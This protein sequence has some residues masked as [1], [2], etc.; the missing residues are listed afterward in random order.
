MLSTLSPERRHEADAAGPERLIVLFYDQV[1]DH[2][3]AAI[4]AIARNDI[5]ERCNA[6]TS[7]TELLGEMLQCFELESDDVI[8]DN[9]RQIHSFVIA[10]LPQVNLYNDAKLLAECIRLLKPIRDAW[11]VTDKVAKQASEGGKPPHPA[12][13]PLAVI[14]KAGR[15]RLTLVAPAS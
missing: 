15:P 8:I 3:H 1:L 10:R 11:A 5:Q 14:G 2:L 12:T 7:A 6:L 13:L 9:L 4:S